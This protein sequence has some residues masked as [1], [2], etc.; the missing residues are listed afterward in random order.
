MQ[1]AY[2]QIEDFY[3]NFVQSGLDTQHS[4]F[5]Q[6]TQ[7]LL[8]MVGNVKGRRVLD[9]CCGEGHLAREFASH[10]A[11]VVGVDLSAVNLAEAERATGSSS[12]VEFVLDDA[13]S[14]Q[15]LED[16]QFDV[17]VCKM[18][19]MDVP[20]VDAAFRAVHRVL[21]P[22]GRFLMA[23]LHPCFETP[24]AVPFE[25]VEVDGAGQFKHRRVQRCFE[26]GLW[27]SGGSGVRGHVGAH[28][29]KLSTYI[30]SLMASGFRLVRL[31]E[32]PLNIGEA[33]SLE[34]QWGEQIPKMLFIE[35]VAE[36]EAE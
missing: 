6:L 8:Q 7:F 30:N 33:D 13:Q 4:L 17:V 9:L 5:F 15:R 19:L 11:E 29:R 28:H 18:A 31:E 10:G 35:V 25:P 27:H 12:S 22:N 34:R 26:E 16:E 14:L 32:P 23:L 36:K 24:F 21:K 3:I 2:D 20:N 1:P